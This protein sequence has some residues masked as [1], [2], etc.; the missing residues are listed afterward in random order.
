MSVS[1]FLEIFSRV[2]FVITLVTVFSVM[3]TMPSQ[4]KAA[5][6]SALRRDPADTKTRIRYVQDLIGLGEYQN[7][8]KEL[9]T[10]FD[11]DKKNVY[12]NGLSTSLPSPG[13]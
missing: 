9:K 4:K 2:L 11:F 7:A 1:R 5:D 6:Y 12:L 13:N 8:M 3:I 10:G